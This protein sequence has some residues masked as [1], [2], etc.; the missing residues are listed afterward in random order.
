[1]LLKRLCIVIILLLINLG[2][3]ASTPDKDDK[4]KS[5]DN[6][7]LAKQDCYQLF[8]NILAVQEKRDV[9]RKDFNIILSDYEWGKVTHRRYLRA[10]D[11]WFSKEKELRSQVTRMY[12]IGYANNCFTPPEKD[13]VSNE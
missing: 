7:L 6:V 9:I 1:M 5:P 8:V 13:E 3:V 12:D 10:K 11:R 4:E 2:C